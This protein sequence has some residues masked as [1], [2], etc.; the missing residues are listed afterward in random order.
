M[1]QATPLRPDDFDSCMCEDCNSFL[2]CSSVS[3][4]YFDS[5]MREDCDRD[6]E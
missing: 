5:C 3:D 4:I 1:P 6:E 2:F